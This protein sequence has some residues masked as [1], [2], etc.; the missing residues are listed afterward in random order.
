M[1]ASGPSGPL[2]MMT[3]CIIDPA[4]CIHYFMQSCHLIALLEDIIL[5]GLFL[6]LHYLTF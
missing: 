2:V 6:R 3:I 5:F 1:S 4:S